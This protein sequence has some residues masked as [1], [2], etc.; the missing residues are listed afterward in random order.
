VR[1]EEERARFEEL[2]S[3]V[4]LRMEELGRSDLIPVVKENLF[5]A[6]I[7]PGLPQDVVHQ[8]EEMLLLFKPVSVF[9]AP[10]GSSF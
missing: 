10:P 8:M 5:G 6:L 2:E 7:E 9:I 4:L 3:R 1:T